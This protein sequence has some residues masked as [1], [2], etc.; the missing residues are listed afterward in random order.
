[1][2]CGA[3]STRASPPTSPTWQRRAPPPRT[4][5]FYRIDVRVE[6]RWRINDDGASWALVLEVLNTT[7]NQEAL[8]KSCSAYVCREDRVGPITIPSLG[9]EALF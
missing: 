4:T 3:R 1:M 5:P 2:A 8:G 7:L 9:L 6:K